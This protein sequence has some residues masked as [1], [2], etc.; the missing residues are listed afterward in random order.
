MSADSTQRFSDRVEHYVRSRPNYPTAFYEFLEKDLQLPSP[1]AVADIGSGTGI[2]ARPLLER[3]HIV[4]AIEPNQPMREAAE[5]LLSHHPKF[6]SIN[7]TA[8]ST[9]LSNC[10]VDLVLAAQAFHWF[11]RAKAR[12]EFE[13]IL[14]PS[15]YVVLVW[16]ERRTDSTPFLREYEQ[17]LQNYATD[18]NTVRHENIDAAALAAFFAPNPYATRSFINAQHFD[19]QGLESRLLSSSYTPAAH[20]PRR[21]PLLAELRRI[22]DRH[23][24]GGHVNFEYDT[25][26]HYGQ[27]T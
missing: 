24:Q 27:L 12:L 15:G 11:D 4:H 8:E 6:H 19:Y 2:S 22:F 1:M 23:Q 16:N 20:D 3:G 5:K 21:A 26:A 18:Y 25:R 17:L 14:K 13:R 10:S 7:G 9:G